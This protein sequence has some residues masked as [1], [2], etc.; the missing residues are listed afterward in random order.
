ME[1]SEFN[2][3]FLS[4]LLEKVSFENKAVVL[5]GDFNANLLKYDTER[6]VSDFLDLMYVNTLLPKI[7]TPSRITAKSATLIDNIFANPFDPSFIS[8]NLTISLSDHLA[9][10]LIMPS[11]KKTQ[12]VANGSPKYHRDMRN[13]D[14]NKDSISTFLKQTDWDK[15]LEVN[16]NNTNTSTELL[17]NS[18]NEILDHYCPLKN[19]KFSKKESKQAMDYPRHTQIHSC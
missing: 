3:H 2:S 9:Q 11:F 10:F 5:S 13:I 19:I 4:D 12:N 7:T 15:K 18:V 17:L 14:T 1:L 6:D 8:G 16:L